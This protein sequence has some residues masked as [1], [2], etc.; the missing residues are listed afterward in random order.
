[1]TIPDPWIMNN[2]EVTV[3]LKNLISVFP[4]PA[5]IYAHISAANVVAT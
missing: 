5:F 1:M 4:L 3:V 2:Q